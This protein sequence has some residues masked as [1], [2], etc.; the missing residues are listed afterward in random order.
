MPT[1]PPTASIPIRET[2]VPLRQLLARDS[3]LRRLTITTAC[4][5]VGRGTF[6]ALT[7]LYLSQIVGLS[8]LTV[9]I[10]LTIAGAAG[11]AASFVG[12]YLAD[13]LSARS[14]LIALHL[15]QGSALV[16][17]LLVSDVVSL[18]VVAA[19]ATASHQA[20]GAVRSSMI[21]RAFAGTERVRIRALL[22][23]TTNAGIAT[24]AAIAAIPLAIG[25]PGAYRTALALSGC[26]YLVSALLLRPLDRSR[27]DASR[28]APAV[29]SVTTGPDAHATTATSAEHTPAH[30]E[31]NPFRNRRY[32]AVTLFCGIIAM[33]FGMFEVGLP[34]WIALKTSAPDVLVSA[35]LLV[36]TVLVVAL[37]IRLSR[38]VTSTANAGRTMRFAGILFALSCG[39]WALSGQLSATAACAILLGTAVLYSIAEILSSAAEWHLSFELANPQSLGAY[40][41]VFGMGTAL[42]AMCAPLLV[43][44]TAIEHGAI[45]WAILATVFLVASLAV[46]ACVSRRPR[47]SRAVRPCSS[48]AGTTPA[49][50]GSRRDRGGT[51]AGGAA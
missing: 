28:L 27:V 20:A 33:H 6:F 35:Q 12:G 29:T 19:T 42:G 30:G 9:G 49:G 21:G 46:W 7:A 18:T 43:T 4:D 44:G 31:T 10:A 40:Q 3:T 16:S 41:G 34:L 2:P 48:A 51:P 36:N 1:H 24:G 37:Q 11:V 39:L 17:Y 14:V 26:L 22:R 32:L 45:G 25:T 5:T 8:A 50:G 47:R 23:T 15:I 13:R 38:V